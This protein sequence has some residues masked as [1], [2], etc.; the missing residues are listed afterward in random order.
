[1]KGEVKLSRGSKGLAGVRKGRGDDTRGTCLGAMY[2][3]MDVFLCN[4][5]SSTVKICENYTQMW[6]GENCGTKDNFDTQRQ[7][8]VT[9][10]SI[11]KWVSRILGSSFGVSGHCRLW[12]LSALVKFW[13]AMVSYLISPGLGHLATSHRFN[14]KKR[15]CFHCLICFQG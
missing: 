7:T 5:V 12:S 14:T 4:T 6:K 13:A 15:Y 2:T 8:S 9:G 1:M 10:I 3:C 11:L